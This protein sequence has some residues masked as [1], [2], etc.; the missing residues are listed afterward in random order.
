MKFKE[1]GSPE[2]PIVILLHGEGLSWWSTESAARRLMGKY[3]VIMPIL[4]G[5][6]EDAETEFVSIED[7]AEKLIHFIDHS[8]DGRIFALCG[9]SLSAQ[10]AAQVLTQRP[11][12][13]EYAVLESALVRPGHTRA[14]EIPKAL[15]R[16]SLR[17]ICLRPIA[18]L[19][20]KKGSL[21][22]EL[23]PQYYRDLP[24]ISLTSTVHMIGSYRNF[25]V[26]ISLK[27]TCAKVLILVGSGESA[28]RKLSAGLLKKA[29]PNSRLIIVRGMRHGELSIAHSDEY[30]RLLKE[31]F[32][33]ES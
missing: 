22:N 23:F 32:A 5:H 13:A 20:A 14:L 15:I 16:L 25:H 27:D 11:E 6:G 12:I 4:D 26:P 21:P 24:K 31:W 2:N 10:I 33:Q 1:L 28:E 19:M 18:R 17:L 9:F 29:V 3:R 8:C 30:V 7:S